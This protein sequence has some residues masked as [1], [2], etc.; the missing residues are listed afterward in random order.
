MRGARWAVAFALAAC[1]ALPFVVPAHPGDGALRCD[2]DG[3][4]VGAVVRVVVPEAGAA[5]RR[6]F[7]SFRCADDWIARLVAAPATARVVDESTGEELDARDAWFVRSTV[8]TS[9]ATGECIHTFRS[10][11]DARAHVAAYGGFVLEGE[12]RP[13]RRIRGGA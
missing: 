4:E 7:C 5:P 9:R 6:T 12:E 11:A 13:L 10:A 2:R 1:A 3:V 8:P